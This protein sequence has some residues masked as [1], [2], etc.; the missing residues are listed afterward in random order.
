MAFETTSEVQ[1]DELRLRL[2]LRR[3]TTDE[4]DR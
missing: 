2:D 3:T 1:W 4:E